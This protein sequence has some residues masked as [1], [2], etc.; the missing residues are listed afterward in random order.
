MSVKPC[1]NEKNYWMAL[2]GLPF[3]K[4]TVQGSHSWV[5]MTGKCLLAKG[6]NIEIVKLLT[7]GLSINTIV[8]L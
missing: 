6:I 3:C 1:L 7:T 2:V 4:M 5:V 8:K